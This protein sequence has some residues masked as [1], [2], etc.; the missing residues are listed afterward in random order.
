[1]G[2]SGESSLSSSG[3]DS[4]NDG[5]READ[6]EHSDWVEGAVEW[7]ASCSTEPAHSRAEQAK[8]MSPSSHIFARQL[9]RFIRNEH[10]QE[11]VFKPP[12]RSFQA[13]PLSSL[14]SSP[15]FQLNR[16]AQHY[17]LEVLK[18]FSGTV[19]LRKKNKG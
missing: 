7:P 13:H 8:P 17:G 15:F 4:G 18:R 16:I 3:T 14:S 11:L 10:Q 12:M 9:Q 5:G 6:D 19:V 2:G 1:M